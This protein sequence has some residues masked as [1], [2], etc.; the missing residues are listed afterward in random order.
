MEKRIQKNPERLVAKI[1]NNQTK[2]GWKDITNKIKTSIIGE[3]QT[4]TITT[5]NIKTKFADM[6]N[7]KAEGKTKT[8]YLLS[9]TTWQPGIRKTYM[10]KLTR[11]E[12][13]TIFKTRT[14]MLDVKKQLQR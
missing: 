8:Q 14:R 3:Q 5:M 6:I 10:N 1:M 9:N 13:S 12:A 4:H 7:T 11:M 2:G